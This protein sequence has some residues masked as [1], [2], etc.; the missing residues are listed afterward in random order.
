LETVT[1][2]PHKGDIIVGGNEVMKIDSSY[3]QEGNIIVKDNATLLIKDTSL[4]IYQPDQEYSIN[5]TNN[6][7]LTVDNSQ[8]RVSTSY[9]GFLL[10]PLNTIYVENNATALFTNSLIIAS[11]VSASQSSYVDIIDSNFTNGAIQASDYANVTILNGTARSI[12]CEEFSTIL[13]RN[14]EAMWYD[15]S[16]SSALFI[17]D[18][19]TDYVLPYSNST[20]TVTNSTIEGINPTTFLG[21]ICFDNSIITHDILVDKTTS[22]YFCGN[23]TITG[24]ITDFEGEM[25]R[26]YNVLTNPERQLTVLNQD[27]GKTL[28]NT[29]ADASG[30]A[31]F[32]IVYTQANY[33]NHL[34][35]NGKNFNSTS[36]TPLTIS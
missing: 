4:N 29:M 1:T 25:T 20:I 32:D 31:Q 18:S 27:T 8:M 34:T 10:Y 12:D 11:S 17:E 22:F 26:N 7:N 5:I 21:K 19:N 30:Y 13:S 6:A 35:I 14:T 33:T 28:L 24:S 16:G 3:I 23:V 36:S 2:Y 9:A 15:A